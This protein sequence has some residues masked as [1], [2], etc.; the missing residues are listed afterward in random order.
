M[1]MTCY[2]LLGSLTVALAIPATAS[3]AITLQVGALPS[4]VL[5]GSSVSLP[6]TAT[7]GDNVDGFQFDILVNN[8]VKILGIDMT[9]SFLSGGSVLNPIP[10]D[11]YPRYQYFTNPQNIA[12]ASGLVTTLLLDTSAVPVNGT[13]TVDLFA[14]QP[15][16]ADTYFSLGQ[17]RAQLNVLSPT[18][19][20]VVVPEPA[21]L[22]VF[23]SAGALLLRRRRAA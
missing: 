20:T 9:G 3:A 22:G 6:I 23:A 21:T 17:D 8:G 14:T 19:V 2:G 16:V 7:G 10:D 12:S 4:N 18:T 13:F 11:T 5:Q 15:D 1:K